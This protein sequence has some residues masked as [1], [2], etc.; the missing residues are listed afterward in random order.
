M[1]V[2]TA[3][4]DK[5]THDL[6]DTF[7]KLAKGIQ[8]DYERLQNLARR[9][10]QRAGH[11]AET[12]WVDLLRTWLPDTYG[13]ETRKYILPEYAHAGEPFET[14]IVV[15]GP[16]T[17]RSLRRGAEVLA[18]AVAAAFSVKLTLDASGIKDA[19][20]RANAL[21]AGLYTRGEDLRSSLVSPFPFALLAH[22][23]RWKSGPAA[24]RSRVADST[25]KY[26]SDVAHPRNLLDAICVPSLGFWRTYRISSSRHLERRQGRSEELSPMPALNEDY[27]ISALNGPSGSETESV[28]VGEFI[29][30]LLI[31]LAYNDETLQPLATHLRISRALGGSRGQQ[32]HWSTTSV[33][34][35]RVI[36][37]M[38]DIGAWQ[39]ADRSWDTI[40]Y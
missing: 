12:A 3:S 23:H 21:K 17:P 8:D 40:F 1:T 5:S 32:R 18:G 11:G 26:S 2:T 39:E 14:D 33:Y 30:W 10:P 9:D 24:A 31:R 6:N 16:G 35:A 25:E 29:C 28:P 19:V 34:D 15:F 38:E 13:V 27:A 4:S 22:D 36:R 20:S 37:L 7:Y